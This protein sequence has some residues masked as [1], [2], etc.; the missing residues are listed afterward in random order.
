MRQRFYYVECTI[1]KGNDGWK[2]WW[3]KNKIDE[4]LISLKGE[5]RGNNPLL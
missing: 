4:W 3:S 2:G 1:A 5:K